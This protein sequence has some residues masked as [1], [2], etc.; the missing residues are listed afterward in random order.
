MNKTPKTVFLRS[1]SEV[2]KKSLNFDFG[3]KHYK[4]EKCVRKTILL[5]SFHSL[6]AHRL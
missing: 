3:V 5:L 6:T 4:A 2:T 1:Q